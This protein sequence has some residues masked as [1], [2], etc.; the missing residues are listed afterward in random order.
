MNFLFIGI[1]DFFYVEL[2]DLRMIK[3][4]VDVFKVKELCF[5]FLFYNVGVL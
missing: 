5:D 3:L 4:C 2:D 1:F